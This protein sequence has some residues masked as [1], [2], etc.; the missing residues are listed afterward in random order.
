MR[1][2]GS[3]LVL[4]TLA[5]SVAACRE[6]ASTSARKTPAES[7]TPQESTSD[8]GVEILASA[9]EGGWQNVDL[10]VSSGDPE[11]ASKD[12]V[13]ER[14]GATSCYAF[15]TREAY[16]AA[17]PKAAGN[18]TLTCWA[19]RWTRNKVGTVSGGLN[20][21]MP[22]ACPAL[23]KS[24]TSKRSDEASAEPVTSEPLALRLTLEPTVTA[25]E[26]I[27]LEG[28][29]NLPDGTE[30]STSVSG[31]AFTGQ[32][33]AVAKGGRWRS[34]PFGPRG[35]LQP[36]SYEASVTLPYGHTQP[37]MIQSQ[38]GRRLEKLSGPLMKTN[39]ELEFM[40]QSATVKANV[41][42]Q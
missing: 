18:F 42:V 16:E 24:E 38:L 37:E 13:Q 26:Q 6:G 28:T 41:R 3:L 19:A 27:L 15:L 35:G 9:T 7:Q 2:V 5:L 17:K 4:A 8:P 32:D 31:G 22:S 12:C 34:G 25:T 21:F 1:H 11:Q 33:K 29:T 30:L 36:G 14:T 10:L 20:N 39:P 23:S 40:G